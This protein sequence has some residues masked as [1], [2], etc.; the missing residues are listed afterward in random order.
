VRADRTR[1]RPNPGE[2]CLAFRDAAAFTWGKTAAEKSSASGVLAAED[3]M[4]A[5]LTLGDGR[6]VLSELDCE[7]V[8][9]ELVALIG[10][11]GAGKSSFLLAGEA[12]DASR[13]P[14][15]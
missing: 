4:S 10:P 1:R 11:V 9:G 5:G 12:V 6:A 2:V 14:P 7:L 15:D 13:T 3:G 8:V